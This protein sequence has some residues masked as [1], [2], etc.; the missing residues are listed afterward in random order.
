[1]SDARAAFSDAAATD[2]SLLE[3]PEVA[4]DGTQGSVIGGLVMAPGAA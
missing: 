4:E 2:V 1:M 3:R